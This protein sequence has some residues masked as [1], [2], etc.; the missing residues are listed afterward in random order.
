M[1]M[2]H[3]NRLYNIYRD[4]EYLSLAVQFQYGPKKLNSSE[5]TSS[6][7]Q[8]LRICPKDDDLKNYRPGPINS[9]GKRIK[10]KSMTKRKLKEAGKS[11]PK[12]LRKN[13]IERMEGDFEKVL[14]G[15]KIWKNKNEEVEKMN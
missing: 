10:M 9:F 2:V 1:Y 7:L 14:K 11:K 6:S 3:H 13:T 4:Y 5:M 8:G 15:K 12:L